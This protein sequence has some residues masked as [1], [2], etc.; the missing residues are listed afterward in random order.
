MLSR[1]LVA[2]Q[3]ARQTLSTGLVYSNNCYYMASN[4]SVYIECSDWLVFGRD[5]TVRT[6]TMETVLFGYFFFSCYRS[7][8]IQTV[9]TQEDK[10]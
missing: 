4:S 10:K 6:I 1:V 8:K 3:S 2:N 7:G 5:F 9:K